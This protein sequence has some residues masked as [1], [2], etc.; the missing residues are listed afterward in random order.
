MNV[1]WNPI[2][3]MDD[4]NGEH[5][6]FAREYMDENGKS[7]FCWLTLNSHG[8][9]NVETG[10]KGYPR[11]I[12][13]VSECTTLKKAKRYAEMNVLWNLSSEGRKMRKTTLGDLLNIYNGEYRVFANSNPTAFLFS[14]FTRCSRKAS[15]CM[16]KIVHDFAAGDGLIEIY[17]ICDPNDLTKEVR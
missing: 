14:N 10:E 1:S 8:G 17:I 4:M 13:V 2:E 12:K 7:C 3:E 16:G 5:T 11:S 6:C 15:M 9:W